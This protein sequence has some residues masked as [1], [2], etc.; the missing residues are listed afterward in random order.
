M[1]EEAK[2]VHRNVLD[3]A[4]GGDVMGAIRAL[5]PALARFPGNKHL[6]TT[7]ASLLDRAGRTE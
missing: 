6:L 4:R 3:M 7:S 2:R 1:D 5:E